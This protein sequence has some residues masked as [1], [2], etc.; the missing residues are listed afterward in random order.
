MAAE[1]IDG[2]SV[3]AFVT[4][5]MRLAGVAAD[6]DTLAR[7][8]P[9]VETALADGPRLNR[10]AASTLEPLAHPGR[11]VASVNSMVPGRWSDGA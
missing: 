6:E 5:A 4:A 8:L 7:V 1:M 3:S 9:L 10:A 11:P 2:P